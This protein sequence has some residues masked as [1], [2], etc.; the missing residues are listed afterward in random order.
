MKN[1][2]NAIFICSFSLFSSFTPNVLS[3]N[4]DMEE[5]IKRSLLT[6]NA[7]DTK[8]TEKKKQLEKE[9]QLAIA[10]SFSHLALKPEEEIKVK[11]E[12]FHI[13]PVLPQKG[14][15]CGY[16][17]IKNGNLLYQWLAPEG[18]L[19]EETQKEIERRLNNENTENFPLEE[20]RSIVARNRKN[21]QAVGTYAGCNLWDAE[22]ENIIKNKLKLPKATYSIVANINEVAENN[23]KILIDLANA[24]EK[25]RLNSNTAHIFI[26]GNM[27][28][29]QKNVGHW[30][31]VVLKKENGN[32]EYYIMDSLGGKNKNVNPMAKSLDN[33]LKKARLDIAKIPA[34]NLLINQAQAACLE[35]NENTALALLK[36]VIESPLHPFAN[37]TF[38]QENTNKVMN[39]LNKIETLGSTDK[40]EAKMLLNKLINLKTR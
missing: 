19:K 3:M 39:M 17:A 27:K 15:D 24:I 18:I 20:W 29:T 32:Y 33:V 4:K 22:I 13:V 26:L 31:A 2:K 1:L 11:E 8:D 5:A 21:R 23:D 16:H 37:K 38:A 9:E 7:K 12:H 14:A 36:E 30:I 6:K 34:L 28:D 10:R 40:K 25:I 35:Y